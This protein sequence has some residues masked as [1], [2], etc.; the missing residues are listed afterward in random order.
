MRVKFLKC[1]CSYNAVAC[2]D[3]KMVKL[4]GGLLLHAA[5]QQKN[6]YLFTW[7]DFSLNVTCRGCLGSVVVGVKVDEGEWL[8][9][10]WS[11][12]RS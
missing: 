6:Y 9:S 3:K 11:F 10:K 2:Y 5:N 12:N 8:L 1:C 7:P 4:P